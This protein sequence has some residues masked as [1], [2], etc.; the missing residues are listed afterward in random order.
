MDNFSNLALDNKI[1]LFKKIVEKKLTQKIREHEIF[2]N[3]Y[4]TIS[5]IKADTEAILGTMGD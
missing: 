4:K 5:K 1:G 2:Q 3:Y